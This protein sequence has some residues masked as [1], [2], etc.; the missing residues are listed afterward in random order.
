MYYNISFSKGIRNTLKILC[1]PAFMSNGGKSAWN[2]IVAAKEGKL[3][4]SEAARKTALTY[5]NNITGNSPRSIMEALASAMKKF[6]RTDDL[7][8]EEIFIHESNLHLLMI[9]AF[10]EIGIK[11][12]NVYDGF[13]FIKN[14]CNQKLFDTIYDKCT[15]ELLKKLK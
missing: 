4:K 14:T 1:M 12:I 10:S 9:K 3:T 11:T 6:I 7:L 13:F 5:L 8:E 15:Y 2:A